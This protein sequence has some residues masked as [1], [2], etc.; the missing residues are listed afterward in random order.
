MYKIII[1]AL[2]IFA[3]HGVNPEEKVDGQTFEID[4]V[5]KVDNNL[6]N[7]DDNINN[8]VSYSKVIK[9]IRSAMLAKSYDLIESVAYYVEKAIFDEF[10]A[11]S[12][13]EITVKKPQAPISA[14]VNFVAVYLKNNRS[15]FYV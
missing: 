8:T 3:F 4:A 11:V 1:D 15:D 10:E 13:I 6:A 7:I 2:K 12:E 9:V 14:D 5:L